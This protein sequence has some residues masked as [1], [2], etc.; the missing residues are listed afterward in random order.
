METNESAI[1]YLLHHGKRKNIGEILMAFTISDGITSLVNGQVLN[2]GQIEE[3]MNEIM[4]GKA[5]EMQIASFLTAL[6]IRGESAEIIQGAASKM[7]EFAS[8][9]SPTVNGTL[10]DTCGTG[11]DYA[12]T[13][14]IS[15]LAALVAAGAGTNIAKHGNRAV[16]SSCG[17]ADILESFGVKIDLEPKQVEQIIS[18]IGIGF[19]FAPKFH[20]AMKFAMPVRKVLKMRTIFNIL[21]PL[22][23]PASAKAHVLGV[24]D[25]ALVEP[26]TKAMAGL[27]ADH[28]F[29]VHSEPGIDEIVPINKVYIGEVMNGQIKFY[30]KTAKDFGLT[31]VTIDQVKGGDLATNTKIAAD[32][33]TNKDQGIRREIVLI[34]AAYAIMA[35]GNA[36]NY[37]DAKTKAIDSLK[38]G[39]AALKLRQ[40]VELSGGSMQKYETALGIIH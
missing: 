14:N 37:E 32:I 18:Q 7:R 33:L 8:K 34:N 29:I 19:M 35:G 25:K 36:T 28:V 22:T 16:S 17:S 4:S 13:F 40:M 15:S 1:R 23:N 5:A 38:S 21:G 31:Q 2:L 20:P 24:Y 3:V 9:I 26:I 27:G 11:G 10:V 6:R 12:G 30:E 39:K